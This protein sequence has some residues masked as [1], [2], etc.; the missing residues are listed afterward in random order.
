MRLTLSSPRRTS[1]LPSRFPL[2]GARR[3]EIKET[4]VRRQK[5]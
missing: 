3:K 4:G 5:L 2:E 1:P